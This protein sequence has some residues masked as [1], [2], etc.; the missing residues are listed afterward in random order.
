MINTFKMFKCLV[1]TRE[2]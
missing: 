1:G 2:Y